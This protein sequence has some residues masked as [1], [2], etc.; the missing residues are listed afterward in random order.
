VLSRCIGCAHYARFITRDAAVSAA[1]NFHFR[2]RLPKSRRFFARCG[3]DANDTREKSGDFRNT[4]I[5]MLLGF[6]RGR[7]AATALSLSYAPCW[8][9]R[10]VIFYRSAR[11]ENEIKRRARFKKA[12]TATLLLMI[13]LRLLFIPASASLWHYA[14][15]SFALFGGCTQAFLLTLSRAV[16]PNWHGKFA[17]VPASKVL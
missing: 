1:A 6:G 11:A 7:G 2:A 8:N 3:A 5:R 12:A 4:I 17:K 13:L 10:T 9:T 14:Y 16:W 15:F